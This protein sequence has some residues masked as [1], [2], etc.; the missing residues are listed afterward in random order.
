MDVM[1]A[2]GISLARRWPA[3]VVLGLAMAALTVGL[4]P[5]GTAVAN[6]RLAFPEETPGPPYYARISSEGAPQTAQWAAIVFY[7]DPSCVPS[8]F[9]LLQNNNIHAVSSSRSGRRTADVDGGADTTDRPARNRSISGQ[10]AP[11]A[12]ELIVIGIGLLLSQPGAVQQREAA[13]ITAVDAHERA[14]MAS[15]PAHL[16]KDRQQH[17]VPK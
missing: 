10:F 6:V 1:F 16:P 8:D 7:R 4:L 12:H 2:G 5:V 11:A 17:E 3:R 15:Q 14:P 13:R 9:N